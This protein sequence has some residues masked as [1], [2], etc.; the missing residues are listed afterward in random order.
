MKNRPKI[1]KIGCFWAQTG[2]FC[3]ILAIF[4]HF[5]AVFGEKALPGLP[6]DDPPPELW[7]PVGERIDYD[8]L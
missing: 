7:F 8:I 5:S 2:C 1:R 4:G 6:W 3:L